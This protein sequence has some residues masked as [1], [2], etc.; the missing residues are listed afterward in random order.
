MNRRQILGDNLQRLA[1]SGRNISEMIT[2]RLKFKTNW[3]AN[4][5]LTFHFHRWNQLK[6]IPL[7]SRLRTGTTFIDIIARSV[8]ETWRRITNSFAWRYC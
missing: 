2:N 3:P 5:M 7:D 4:G 6:V 8:L 1:T